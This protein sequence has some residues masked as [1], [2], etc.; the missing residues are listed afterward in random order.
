M[1]SDSYN[2]KR[3]TKK[4]GLYSQLKNKPSENK[5]FFFFLCGRGWDKI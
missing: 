3:N 4:C 2:K 1:K 5:M